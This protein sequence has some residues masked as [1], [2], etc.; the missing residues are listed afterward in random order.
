MNLVRRLR[1]STMARLAVRSALTYKLRLLLT[2]L[3]VVVGTG[4]ISGSLLLTNSLDKSFS[5]LLD[6]GVEGVDIGMVGK[7]DDITSGVPFSVVQEIASRPDVRAVNITGDGNNTPSGTQKIG[8]SALVVTTPQGTPLQAGSSGAHPFAVYPSGY[9]VGPE[10]SIISGRAPVAD[11]EIMLNASAANRGNISVGDEVTVVTVNGKLNVTV[12]GIFNSTSDTAG[13]I[14]VGFSLNRYLELFTD[15]NKATQIVIAAASGTDPM[16]LRNALGQKY[17]RSYTILTAAQISERLAGS[18][19]QQ[20]SFITY[21][22]AAFGFI[23]L[24]IGAFLVTNTFSMTLS[25]RAREFAL[26]RAIGISAGQIQFS[27]LLEAFI[28][29]VLGS[30]IGVTIGIVGVFLGVTVLNATDSS[31]L[32]S[33]S[34]VLSESAV[35]VPLV[36][37][38]IVTVLAA[39]GPMV[40]VGKLR[41]VQAL[42]NQATSESG[43][44]GRTTTGIVLLTV[45][46]IFGVATAFVRSLNNFDLNTDLRLALF[47]G[48]ILLALIAISAL[49]PAWSK[50]FA[51]IFSRPMNRMGRVLPRLANRNAMR[52]PRR[53]GRTAMALILGVGLIGCVTVIGGTTKQSVYGIIGSRVSSDFVLGSIGGSQVGTI[54]SDSNSNALSVPNAAAQEVRTVPG[55]GQTAT[56]STTELQINKW[57]HDFAVV[58][59]N[60]LNFIDLDL[61]SGTSDLVDNPGMI[62]SSAYAKDNEVTVGDQV[63]VR[64]PN[65]L[66]G[67]RVT[68][69]GIYNDYS[70]IG[71][72]VFDSATAHL[73]VADDTSYVV[74]NIFIRS[75]GSISD[76]QLRSNLEEAMNQ[77]LIV[78]VKN[79]TEF[80]D[81]L[82]TQVN[83]MLTLVYCLLVLAVIV[84]ALGIMNTLFLSVSER[85]Q[86]IAMLR[87]IGMHRRQVRRMIHLESLQIAIQGTIVGLS[88]GL[89]TGWGIVHLLADR[90]M[91]SAY[92]PWSIIGLMVLGSVVLTSLAASL[93]AWRASR[94]PALEAIARD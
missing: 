34:L 47:G 10:P 89:L 71:H 72:V 42:R 35:L 21:V 64:K 18:Y 88:L 86:E 87:T 1:R 46:V 52:N 22:L 28:V 63:V 17:S 33:I 30:I 12:T 90:G 66:D 11:D 8:Q 77:Y 54:T 67:V 6:A 20:L 14:G 24:I 16:N 68:I 27:V 5:T 7:Q 15:G 40:T 78:Q 4:F 92:F 51:G 31:G 25:Q 38:V 93:P 23:A 37:G 85:T 75:D 55:V 3:A 59:N 26:L 45:A 91:G 29:G 70:Y 69:Q 19:R 48:S 49:L 9:Y 41:P 36:G 73:L 50:V 76:S 58:D 57:T 2:V 94:T 43:I 60:I 53:T 61:R 62:V 81:A 80:K 84:A 79:R 56:V 83:Q 39:L 13:W 74:K 82:G 44:R 32:N 65:S